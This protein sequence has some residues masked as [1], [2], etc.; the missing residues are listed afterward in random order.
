MY[1]TAKRV[2]GVRLRESLIPCGRGCAVEE[3]QLTEAFTQKSYFSA[4]ASPKEQGASAE[5]PQKVLKLIE[6]HGDQVHF[7]LQSNLRPMHTDTS[8]TSEWNCLAVCM[9]SSW[10]R[11]GLQGL[12]ELMSVCKLVTAPLRLMH[13]VSRHS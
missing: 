1:L 11:Q 10:T 4:A 8:M 2:S 13:G 12:Q 9:L 3:L 5:Q 7:H 6:S